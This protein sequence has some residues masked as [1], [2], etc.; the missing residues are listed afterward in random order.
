MENDKK[1]PQDTTK[2]NEHEHAPVKTT[3]T[4]GTKNTAAEEGLNK[5]KTDKPGLEPGTSA[6][7]DFTETD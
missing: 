1:H 3:G 2:T 7:P 5:T 4:D 6:D